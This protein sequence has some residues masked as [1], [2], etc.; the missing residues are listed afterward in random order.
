[1]LIDLTEVRMATLI[2]HNVFWICGAYVLCLLR[3]LP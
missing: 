3:L 1:M 2:T